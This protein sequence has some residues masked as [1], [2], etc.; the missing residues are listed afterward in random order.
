MRIP[1]AC[2]I[3]LEFVINTG[4]GRQESAGSG[5]MVKTA[6]TSW[7]SRSLSAIVVVIPVHCAPALGSCILARYILR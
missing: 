4:M 1:R 7:F 2:S 3:S 6:S 5:A